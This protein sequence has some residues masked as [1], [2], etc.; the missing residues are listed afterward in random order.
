MKH[1]SI[2]S[3]EKISQLFQPG[4]C[5]LTLPAQPVRFLFRDSSWKEANKT[6]VTSNHQVILMEGHLT[7]QKKKLPLQTLPR[8]PPS[9]SCPA[10]P[11]QLPAG[12]ESKLDTRPNVC[13]PKGWMEN[14]VGSERLSGISSTLKSK[15]NNC[16]K[17]NYI[18]KNIDEQ[19]GCP[20][21]D[22]SQTTGQAAKMRHPLVVGSGMNQ[23]P[24]RLPLQFSQR[25]W[26]VGASPST[27]RGEKRVSS[28]WMT[29]RPCFH[30]RGN[31]IIWPCWFQS[32]SAAGSQVLKFIL[33]HLSAE[34]QSGRWTSVSGPFTSCQHH[35][36]SKQQWRFARR[37]SSCTHPVAL[38]GVFLHRVGQALDQ[39]PQQ[40][41]ILCGGWRQKIWWSCSLRGCRLHAA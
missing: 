30:L 37:A 35:T 23:K 22:L 16:H 15:E 18:V 11:W 28:S 39:T 6:A 27:G 25:C 29:V 17:I 10:H 19:T 40:V 12:T 31:L 7:R 14:Q 34:L 5:S 41:F 36:N 1:G 2:R 3:W 32:M 26:F 24:T 38:A 9:S 20:N 4:L 21:P 13:A 8:P 33:S